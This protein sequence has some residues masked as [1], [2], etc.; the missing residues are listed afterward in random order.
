MPFI[1][2]EL[3]K[4][5]RHIQITATKAVTDVLAGAY[6]SAFKG[7]GIEFEEV[8]TYQPGDDVRA[9]DWNVTARMSYPYVKRF[10]E[11]RDLTVFLL[12][13]LSASCRFGSG[14]RSKQEVIAEIAALL[15]FS[16]IQNNDNVGLILFSNQIEQY[17][18]PKKGLRHVLRV[19]RD[20]LAFEPISEKTDL[21][22]A[23]DFFNKVHKK[24]GV[25]FIISDFLTELPEKALALTSKKQDLIAIGVVDPLELTFPEIPLVRMIDLE[26]GQERLVNTSSD[27][28]KQKIGSYTEGKLSEIKSIAEK[29]SSDFIRIESDRSYIDP[30]RRAFALR[31]NRMGRIR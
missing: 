14:S 3:L 26:S 1:D 16:A 30:I 18:P 17:I 11:E 21:K 29:E 13:D 12:V 5:V 28:I 22:Q 25:C 9:I 19:I 2:K 6:H 24:K 4:Q 20:L 23:L 31:K 7:R 15:A 8:R 27:L 10:R